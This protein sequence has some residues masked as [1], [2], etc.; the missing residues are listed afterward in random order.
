MDPLEIP[1]VG[2]LRRKENGS[3]VTCGCDLLLQGVCFQKGADQAISLPE[4]H[5]WPLK[6]PIRLTVPA[7]PSVT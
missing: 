2:Y 1:A 5:K 7:G 6:S 4:W 3:L